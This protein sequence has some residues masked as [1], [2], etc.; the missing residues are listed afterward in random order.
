MTPP[1]GMC[2]WTPLKTL[3]IFLMEAFQ[4]F[5]SSVPGA[6]DASN[7]VHADQNIVRKVWGDWPSLNS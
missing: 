2:V 4:G 5:Q 3:D 7:Y 1:W 6:T